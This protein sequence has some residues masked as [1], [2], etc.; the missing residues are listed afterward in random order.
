MPVAKQ[1]PMIQNALYLASILHTILAVGAGALLSA[2]Y[3]GSE[4]GP[5]IEG[6]IYLASIL[7]MTLD[8]FLLRTISTV[9]NHQMQLNKDHHQSHN[10]PLK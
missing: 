7:Y 5:L 10:L 1:E 2:G 6:S 3:G 9:D 4:T 8:D